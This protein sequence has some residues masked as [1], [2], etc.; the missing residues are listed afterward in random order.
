M[1]IEYLVLYKILK[2]EGNMD[3]TEE[4]IES[5][6]FALG[7]RIFD[8]KLNRTL[9]EGEVKAYYLMRELEEEVKLNKSSLPSFFYAR[10]KR[11][12]GGENMTYWEKSER[13]QRIKMRLLKC[14]LSEEI[15]K[16]YD[17]L[18]AERYI[19]SENSNYVL[20]SS[21]KRNAKELMD[22]KL[23]FLRK[24]I[25]F[26]ELIS[27]EVLKNKEA[28]ILSSR[29][30]LREELE[31]FCVDLWEELLEMEKDIMVISEINVKKYSESEINI[32]QEEIKKLKSDIKKYERDIMG[33]MG[34]F[35]AIFSLLGINVSF[36]AST[37]SNSE[38]KPVEVC[39]FLMYLL[40]INIIV[41][42][43]IAA[44]FGILKSY[45]KK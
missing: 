41:I 31:I 38:G 44:V 4:A 32:L 12:K 6:L 3:K 9:T 43:A 16:K 26:K 8:K 19:R 10:M 30:L 39:E 15:S 21:E 29:A 7:E 40:G 33:T 45:T 37:F 23:E 35:L 24:L 34:I 17:E 18:Y 28:K 2:R 14:E 20:R 22:K 36:F 42:L 11:N 5:V 1:K 27:K 25:E 13:L